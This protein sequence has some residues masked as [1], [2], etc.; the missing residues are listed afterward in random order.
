M[1][2]QKEM[3]TVNGKNVA[4]DILPPF[5]LLVSGQS[6][7]LQIVGVVLKC[8]I[9]VVSMIRDSQ[10]INSVFLSKIGYIFRPIVIHFR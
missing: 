3:I 5:V 2:L 10:N 8:F 7:I 1:L 6:P 9:A 4:A